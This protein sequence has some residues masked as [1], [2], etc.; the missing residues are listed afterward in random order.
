MAYL[1]LWSVIVGAGWI[2]ITYE[3]LMKRARWAII[4]LSL[5]VGVTVF[6]DQCKSPITKKIFGIT[7]ESPNE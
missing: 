5:L 7:K 4:F 2:L 6:K 1:I 3:A